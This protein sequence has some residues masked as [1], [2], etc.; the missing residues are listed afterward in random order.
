MYLP[1][2]DDYHVELFWLAQALLANIRVCQ[3]SRCVTNTL[4]YNT[5]AKFAQNVL[6]LFVM[7]TLLN[8]SKINKQHFIIFVTYERVQ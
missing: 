2:L 4:A 6:K 7:F 3:M 8:S 1:S 5:N